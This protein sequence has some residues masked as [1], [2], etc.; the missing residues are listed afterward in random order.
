MSK[1][2]AWR[3]NA[4]RTVFVRTSSPAASPVEGQNERRKR[5][6][7]ETRFKTVLD[8]SLSSLANARTTDACTL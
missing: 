3:L 1:R 2:Q 7:M 4:Y 5:V 6:E 8:S